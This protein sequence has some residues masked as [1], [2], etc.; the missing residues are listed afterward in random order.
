MVLVLRLF[1]FLFLSVFAQAA[2]AGDLKCWGV[3]IGQ[4]HSVNQTYP[5]Q[6]M[7]KDP[8]LLIAKKDQYSFVVDTIE[9]DSHGSLRLF[10]HDTKGDYTAMSDG[11]FKLTGTWQEWRLQQIIGYETSSPLTVSLTCGRSASI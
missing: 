6:P 10:I 8:T 11:Q 7:V 5:L 3:L 4:G 9:L 2:I 1:V